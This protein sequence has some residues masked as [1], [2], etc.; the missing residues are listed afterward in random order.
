MKTFHSKYTF[1]EINNKFDSTDRLSLFRQGLDALEKD[2]LKESQ[3]MKNKYRVNYTLHESFHYSIVEAANETEADNT[4]FNKLGEPEDYKPLGV[5]E[6]KTELI[7]PGNDSALVGIIN[8]LIIDEWEAINGYN[9]ASVTAQSVGLM[10]TAMLFADLAKEELQHVGELQQLMKTFDANTDA[11]ASGEEEAAEKLDE[12]FDY[13]NIDVNQVSTENLNTEQDLLDAGYRYVASNSPY[14][15]Y[16][17]IISGKGDWYAV[18]YGNNTLQHITYAQALGDEP[19]D[20]T[21]GIKMLSKELGKK[22]LPK[23]ESVEDLSEVE[24]AELLTTVAKKYRVKDIEEFKEG[25]VNGKYDRYIEYSVSEP[26][27]SVEVMAVDMSKDTGA[28][29]Y[30]YFVDIRDGSIIV[31]VNVK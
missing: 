7:E 29:I 16:R 22:L 21:K 15:L 8:K 25:L 11:I 27:N 6:I 28:V 31:F 20:D 18:N 4:V 17:K 23:N 5:E 24:K 30:R 19:I 3:R 1:E 10:D 13:E 14:D 12:S 26:T 2:L 9:D